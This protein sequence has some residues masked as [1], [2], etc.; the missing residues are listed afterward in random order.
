MDA[1][2]VIQVSN[3]HAVLGRWVY[4]CGAL[5]VYRPFLGPVF[6]WAASVPEEA[7]LPTPKAITFILRYLRDRLR[8]GERMT[9]CPAEDG[10]PV[11][12]FRADATAS[13][14]MVA[15]G[16]WECRDCTPPEKARWF[17]VQLTRET[18]PWIWR[19]GEPFRKIA[20]LELLATLFCV[21]AFGTAPDAPGAVVERPVLTLSGT[22]DNKG[23][24]HVVA[25]LLTT[26]F[27]L[28]AV[29]MQLAHT[30]ASQGRVLHL[31][32]APRDQNTEAD[33]LANMVV[34]R[35]DQS[36]RVHP[37]PD[38]TVMNTMLELG[39]RLYDDVREARVTRQRKRFS[40][41]VSKKR[42]KARAE[43]LKTRAPWE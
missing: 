22:T 43:G 39:T 5:D 35:F 20:G 38:L 24:S 10:T 21:A 18:H 8:A 9:W 29:L 36:K 12:A 19:D 27:P 42:K 15:I 34:H 2:G 25:R 11:E 31:H 23:N 1:A 41:M 7:T 28:S 4:A 32:W 40:N 6:A 14:E 30:L 37:A 17:A 13:D 26:T 16:G 3:L 33:A